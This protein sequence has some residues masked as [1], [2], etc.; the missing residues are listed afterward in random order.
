MSPCEHDGLRWFPVAALALLYSLHPADQLFERAVDPH[1]IELRPIVV[2]EAD[3]FY[4]DIV[5]LPL[6]A[7]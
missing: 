3:V 2:D 5:D 4:D 6:I 1:A 7:C